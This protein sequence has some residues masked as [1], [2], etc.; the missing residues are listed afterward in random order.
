[1]KRLSVELLLERQNPKKLISVSPDDRVSH[2][3]KLMKLHEIGLVTVQERGDLVGVISERDLVQRWI[4]DAKFPQ[5]LQVSEIMTKNVEVITTN[6]TI[7][8]SYL[9]FIAR[10]CRHLPVVD[11]MGR[12][13]GVLSLRDVSQYVVSKLGED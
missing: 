9:R 4:C 10:N 5:D 3:A 7:K 8:D 6:D 2:A 12:V 11:P 13:V 1:M